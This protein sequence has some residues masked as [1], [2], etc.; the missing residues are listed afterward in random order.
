M[1]RQPNFNDGVPASSS[2]KIIFTILAVQIAE[3][4]TS[5]ANQR[6]L[7]CDLE[8]NYR[9]T[10]ALNGREVYFANLELQCHDQDHDENDWKK[11]HRCN[12]GHRY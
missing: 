4:S 3:A 2:I 7:L 5:R 1:C 9:P 10:Q 8:N 6:I 12:I 11:N